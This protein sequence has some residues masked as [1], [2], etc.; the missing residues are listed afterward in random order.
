MSEEAQNTGRPGVSLRT[1]AVTA[2]AYLK[3][4]PFNACATVLLTAWSFWTVIGGTDPLSI[5][6]GGLVAVFVLMRLSHAASGKF[7]FGLIGILLAF[8][9]PLRMMTGEALFTETNVD[10]LFLTDVGEAWDFMTNIPANRWIPSAVML[11]VLLLISVKMKPLQ[12]DQGRLSR[13]WALLA[14]MA[15][16]LIFMTFPLTAVLNAVA[17]TEAGPPSWHMTGCLL[18]HKPSQNYV[19]FLGESLRSDALGLYGN[20]YETTP[21]LSSIPTKTLSTF[22]SR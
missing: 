17:V 10:T 22:V 13:A 5:A 19:I 21:Y 7:W 16:P 4:Y 2:A 15:A 14:V 20:R 6:E 18:G 9:M 11:A 8:L 3:S 12:G 1:A